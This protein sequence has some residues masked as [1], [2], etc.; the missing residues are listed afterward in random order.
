MNNSPKDLKLA[1]S[2]QQFGLS[3]NESA[4]WLY[5][6]QNG[7]RGTSWI[8]KHLKLNRGTTHLVLTQL[9][10]KRL[11]TQIE[12]KGRSEFLA[13][14][15]H[16]LGRIVKKEEEQIKTRRAVF[17][18]I[19]PVLSKIRVSEK[20][21]DPSIKHY[22]GVDGARK[23]LCETLKTKEM[24]FRMYIS[25]Y[26]IIDYVGEDFFRQ[27]T[28]DRINRGYSARIISLESKDDLAS[29]FFNTADYG[30]SERDRRHIKYLDSSISYPTTMYIVDN[31]ICVISSKDE[32]YSMIVESDELSSFQ[33]QIFDLLWNLLPE[34]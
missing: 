15:P 13:C 6:L 23:V 3:K 5:L 4:I 32:D 8:A 9:I 22:S 2:L 12:R 11:V 16:E 17:E 29:K 25:L 33:R 20:H 24:L 18:Q 28:Q 7:S 14:E 1:Q 19:L 10:E 27:F 34:K 26:D 21:Q 30:P 31:K